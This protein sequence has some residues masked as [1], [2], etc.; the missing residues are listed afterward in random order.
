MIT[1]LDQYEVEYKET[2]ISGTYDQVVMGKMF[3]T[4]IIDG[5]KKLVITGSRGVVYG[6]INS[7]QAGQPGTNAIDWTNF[8]SYRLQP[9]REKAG[10]CRAAKHVCYEERIYDTLAPNPLSCF[11]ANGANV[12]ALRS[13]NAY[14]LPGATSGYAGVDIFNSALI[15]FDNYI[16]PETALP[17]SSHIG[18]LQSNTS[19]AMINPCV[20]VHWTKSFPFEPRYSSIKREKTQDFSKVEVSYL[21]SFYGDN[22]GVVTA[23]FEPVDKLVERDP[24][25]F[26]KPWG[27][28][29][30]KRIKSGLIVGTVSKNRL[31][32]PGGTPSTAD[33]LF[34]ERSTL[35]LASSPPLSGNIFHRWATDVNTQKYITDFAGDRFPSTGSCGQQDLIKVLFGYGDNNTVFFDHQLTSSSD[36]TGYARRGTH[37]WPYFRKIQRTKQP[38]PVYGFGFPGYET[39]SSSIWC[40]SPIIRG[41]KYGLYNGL[42]DYTSAYYRQGRYGQFRD[43]LEQRMYTITIKE[44]AEQSIRTMV[45]LTNKITQLEGPVSVKFLDENENLTDPARTQ[46]QNLSQFATSSLPYFDLQ[47]RNRPAVA[48]LPNLTLV[49]FTVDAAGNVR[50]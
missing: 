44:S 40:V 17:M 23:S 4:A 34:Y 45:S 36:E 22:N 33:G 31:L 11:K 20:D 28:R 19:Q 47:Q 18:T 30:G 3:E 13:E 42:P 7:N 38:N 9:Y 27:F 50:I 35:D 12:F 21:G 14:A 39:V 2:Y 15:M 37:N 29:G 10:N 26:S 32:N 8:L 5:V 43:L 48:P 24:H 16:P 6:S 25:D 46:S 41:W 49:G 1:V